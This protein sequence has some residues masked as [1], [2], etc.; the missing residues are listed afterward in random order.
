MYLN[1]RRINLA[2]WGII[3]GWTYWFTE[4]TYCC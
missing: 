4:V 1:M 3:W 2:T